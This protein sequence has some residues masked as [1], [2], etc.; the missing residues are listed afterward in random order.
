MGSGAIQKFHESLHL[1]F[2]RLGLEKMYKLTHQRQYTLR[3]DLLGW[4]GESTY[5]EYANFYIDDEVAQYA[6]HYSG[7]SGSAGDE[8]GSFH[9]GIRF[10][11]E[12]RD[13]DSTDGANCAVGNGPFWLNN[14]DTA[15]TNGLYGHNR[16]DGG[17]EWGDIKSFKETTMRIRPTFEDDLTWEN[18]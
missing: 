2:Y 9:Q 11:T 15:N 16:G 6:I 5:A 7:Y 13:N 14:C 1:C 12:D 17:I 8:L 3:V 4:E 18:P 10:S